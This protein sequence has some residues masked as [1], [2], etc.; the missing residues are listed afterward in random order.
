MKLAFQPATFFFFFLL[1]IALVGSEPKCPRCKTM[2]CPLGQIVDPETHCKLCRCRETLDSP[3]QTISCKVD[4]TCVATDNGLPKC[5]PKM[6]ELDKYCPVA[7]NCPSSPC[8][9]HSQCQ[10]KSSQ[11]LCCQ[12]KCGSQ[13]VKSCNKMF[14]CNL[15]CPDGLKED[16]YGCSICECYQPCTNFHCRRQYECIEMNTPRYLSD[17]WLFFDSPITANVGRYSIPKKIPICRKI[18]RSGSCPLNDVPLLKSCANTKSCEGDGECNIG[19][20][21]CKH[22]RCRKICR[23]QCPYLNNCSLKC[24]FGLEI[25]ANACMTCKCHDPCEKSKCPPGKKCRPF[26]KDRVQCVDENKY[27]LCPSKGKVSINITETTCNVDADCKWTHKCC[28]N[29][30]N[31]KICAIPCEKTKCTN[32]CFMGSYKDD[33]YGCPTC[34][35]KYDELKQDNIMRYCPIVCPA[36]MKC[37]WNVRYN[38]HHPMC[39][40]IT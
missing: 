6:V 7:F 37:R 24:K 3:C 12:T 34:K 33:E 39:V 11:L 32:N 17:R 35:C 40:P 1:S 14:S 29:Y 8:S 2:R 20:K 28:K 26:T 25:L 22:E 18:I 9:T 21:C 27:G 4:E 19:E 23:Q 30:V 38:I 15:E 10:D 31:G 16:K 36:N 5:L 13:C